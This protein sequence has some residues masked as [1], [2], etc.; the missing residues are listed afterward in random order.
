M[1]FTLI[2]L[3]S[4]L[5][6]FNKNKF[7]PYYESDLIYTIDRLEVMICLFGKQFHIPLSYLVFALLRVYIAI[8]LLS[9]LLS[10]EVNSASVLSGKNSTLLERYQV[11]PHNTSDSSDKYIDN[12]LE[13]K[14][15]PDFNIQQ[16]TIPHKETDLNKSS[17]VQIHQGNNVHRVIE[18]KV[19]NKT[20][21]TQNKKN[22]FLKN[23]STRGNS[24]L[25]SN[26]KVNP[27]SDHTVRTNVT[28][29]GNNTTA[30]SGVHRVTKNKSKTKYRPDIPKSS[31]NNTY[32]AYK[33]AKGNRK[34][35]TISILGL[36]ELT[37]SND[38]LRLEGLSEL[39]AAKLAVEHVNKANM[40]YDYHLELHTN[41]TKVS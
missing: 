3:K 10:S 1:L 22:A 11:T 9:I 13:N 19:S 24:T 4:S 34:K 6:Y 5:S 15:I 18:V 2:F 26:T 28:K 27:T 25:E 41:D 7:S 32:L 14:T 12:S 21:Q 35:Q 23:N 36:F 40:L 31:K 33:N 39:E 38:E 17:T 37:E 29:S 8:Q 30:T 20:R 16:T